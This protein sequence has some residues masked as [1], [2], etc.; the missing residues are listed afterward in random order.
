MKTNDYVKFVTQQV[1]EYADQP[2]SER[3]KKRQEKKE[4][5]P[6]AMH[7]WFGLVPFAFLLV[8]KKNRNRLLK[9]K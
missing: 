6:P 2:K 3:I 9:Q 7:R 8:Y 1:V 4:A 5:R